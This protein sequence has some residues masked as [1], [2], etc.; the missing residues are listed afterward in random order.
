MEGREGKGREGGESEGKMPQIEELT[1]EEPPECQAPV[2][3]EPSPKSEEKCE[4]DDEKKETEEEKAAKQ[5]AMQRARSL[6][7]DGNKYFAAYDYDNAVAMYTEAIETAPDGEKEKAVFYN[8]RA[9]CYFKM[10][11]HE[12]VIKDCSSALKIDPEYSK[13][14][15]RRAQERER[16]KEE[17]LG[18]LKDLGNTVEEFSL[19]LQELMVGRTTRLTAG[20]CRR[21]RMRREGIPSVSN[22]EE[23]AI[24]LPCVQIS[25]D[26]DAIAQLNVKEALYRIDEIV[27]H[28]SQHNITLSLGGEPVSA[29]A[30]NFSITHLIF[31][32]LLVGQPGVN[33]ETLAHSAPVLHFLN[34]KYPSLTSAVGAEPHPLPQLRC[35]P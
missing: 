17:M 23:L 21:R 12:Q 33:R 9:T 18:K 29:R 31:I 19:F 2:F 15:L 11:N 26:E 16:Q 20:W 35:P 22:S 14:L 3:Q 4:A 6:K 27:H 32:C 30:G 10:G 7:E 24:E 1:L 13:C 5:E 8:N 34:V 28:F 25:L